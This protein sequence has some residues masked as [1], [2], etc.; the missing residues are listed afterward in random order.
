MLSNTKF[1][2]F[3]NK[4]AL[5]NP[6]QVV[7]YTIAYPIALVFRKIGLS[8][9]CVTLIS[10][11]FATIAFLSLV[12]K[13]IEIF[14]LTWFFSY[15]LD[16]TDGTLARLA[17][18]I[19][20][21]ALRYDHI[22]DQIKI[23]IIFLG[24]GIYYQNQIIWILIFLSST[25]FLFY[26]LLNHEV[27]SANKLTNKE[28]KDVLEQYSSNDV[29]KLKLLKRYLI[30]KFTVIKI[31][32]V[33]VYGTFYIINGHTLLIFFLIPLGFDCALYSLT[34]FISICTVQSFHRLVSLSKID[35]V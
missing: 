31:T 20:T 11:I 21:K 3:S 14:I 15:L 18:K 32:Y 30:R 23:I 22:S 6:F 34:Y 5:H 7:L 4:D 10:F 24:F 19:G 28:K 25:L 1:L 26:S 33:F 13:N 9:N 17:N 12:N 8:P 2:S 35:K 29:S 27:S 16:Y